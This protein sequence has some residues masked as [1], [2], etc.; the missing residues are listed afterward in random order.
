VIS[1]VNS[2]WQKGY[3][4]PP[5]QTLIVVGRDLDELQD[6]F[7]SCRLAAHTWNRFHVLNEETR[8]HPNIFVCRTLLQP[9]PEYWKTARHFG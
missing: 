9:W 2:F 1:G 8:A 6:H 7:A 4:D 5:P 3:G